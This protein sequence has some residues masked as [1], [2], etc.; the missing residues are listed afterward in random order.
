MEVI[1]FY[2][3]GRT[4]VVPDVTKIEDYAS[5]VFILTRKNVYAGQKYEVGILKALV[6]SVKVRYF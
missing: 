5:D 1:L 6:Q 4:E 3:N 2:K